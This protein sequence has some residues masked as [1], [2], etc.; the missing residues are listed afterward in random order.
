MP[1]CTM[2]GRVHTSAACWPMVDTTDGKQ[3]TNT[4]TPVTYG[5]ITINGQVVC[6]CGANNTATGQHMDWC[7][8]VVA[9]QRN[10]AGGGVGAS[11][12][13]LRPFHIEQTPK[14]ELSDADIDR[15]ARRVV[16][17]LGDK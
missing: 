14:R 9:A 2:C 13:P 1:A 12:W 8:I 4:T 11:T 3:W 6:N 17:L 15:I 7:S 10:M 16:E 5:T